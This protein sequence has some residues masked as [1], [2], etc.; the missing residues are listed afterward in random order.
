[1]N[2]SK[3]CDIKMQFYYIVGFCKKFNLWNLL[4]I[5]SPLINLESIESGKHFPLKQPPDTF[6]KW[7]QICYNHKVT[8]K[9][10]D[11]FL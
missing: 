6:M 1:M 11:F 7:C 5:S 9:I 8:L 4:N 2:G 10:Y 3:N